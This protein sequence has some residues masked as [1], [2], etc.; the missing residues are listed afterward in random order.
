MSWTI[1]LETLS[2]SPYLFTE[3]NPPGLFLKRL[4][5]FGLINLETLTLQ[6]YSFRD[7]KCFAL[8]I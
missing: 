5:E 7:S 1:T 3:T 2:F 4:K 6:A 8:L